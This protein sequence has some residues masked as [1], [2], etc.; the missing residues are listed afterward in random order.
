MV[1]LLNG[2]TLNKNILTR[3]NLLN[4]ICLSILL[5]TVSLVVYYRIKMQISI[6]PFW[7]TYAY[8]SNALE[9]A[10]MG[11]GYTELDRPPF[12]PFLTSLLFRLGFISEVAIYLVEGLLF[13]FGV[14]GLYIFFKLRFNPVECLAGALVFVSFPITL[15]WLGVGYVDLS[16]VSLSIWALYTTVL[17]VNR[18]PK[19]FYLAFPLAMMAFLTRFTAGFIVFP[20]ILYI[21][22]GKHYLPHFKHMLKGVFASFLLIIPYLLYI[23]QRTGDPF[24]SIMWSLSFREESFQEHF[25]YSSDVLYYLHNSAS[26]ISTKGSLHDWIYYIFIAI[27]VIGAIIYVYNLIKDWKDKNVG[28]SVNKLKIIFLIL[29]VAGFI[30]TFT[31]VNYIICNFLVLLISYLAYDL[32]RGR[33][34]IDLDILFFSWFMIQFITQSLFAIKVDRYFLTMAPALTYFLILGLH[35]ISQKIGFKSGKIGLN[36]DK[37]RSKPDIIGF[38]SGKVNSKSRKIIPIIL[39]CL[40]IILA[41]SATSIYLSDVQQHK[42][43]YMTGDM[44]KN[45]LIDDYM[46]VMVE[47]LTRYDP[48]YQDKK[49]Q[50]EVWPGFVW[51][52]KTGMEQ[53]P[54]FNTTDELNHWLEK[55]DV[56][57]YISL[58]PVN[59]SSYQPLTEY[60]NMTLYQK[61]PDLSTN[62]TNMLYVG[63]GWQNYIDQ[64]LGLKAYVIHESQGRLVIGKATEIDSHSLEELQQYPYILLFNFKWHN[65]PHAEQLLTEY[66]ESGGT[67]IIDASGNL[68]GMYYNLDNGVFLNTSITKKSLP[69]NP[70]I[71]PESINF[72]PFLSDGDT[73]YGAN[74]ES[75][76]ENKIQP[77]ITANN[78]TLIGVQKIGK[79]RIIWIGYNFVWHAFHMEN[80]DEMELIQESI[81]I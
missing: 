8:L 59:L 75:T 58:N 33:P 51:K 77:L 49:V 64:V 22:M 78:Q 38:N 10:G 1:I 66:V 7:D 56:D 71:Q 4:W 45:Q 61:N 2:D 36:S 44:M 18:N 35:E 23:Y 3:S 13:I 80:Q 81:G 57:Y 16:A 11:T 60:N 67:L 25:A 12:L 42:D 47:E 62:K 76:G 9:Y 48:S 74:Y 20:M 19:F 73:W 55:K 32:L 14:I 28:N 37:I 21:I 39:P 63:Q 30:L 6:G 70:Q 29:L 15:A 40:V 34:K 27:M 26:Y 24:F 50:S 79:G 72:S 43:N 65:Q 5:L 31:R 52:L 54:T 68:E 53:Q 69:A 17:A 41:L 46:D